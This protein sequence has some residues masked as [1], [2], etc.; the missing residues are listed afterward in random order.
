MKSKGIK[1]GQLTWI[2]GYGNPQRRDDGIGPY[3][4]NQLNTFLKHKKGVRI[5]TLNQLEPDL[6]NKLRHAGIIIF[7]DATMDEVEGG[8]TWAKIEP[9]L[10]ILPH[11]TYYFKPSF[12]LGLLQSIYHICPP[13]WLVSVQGDDFEFGEELTREAEKRAQRVVSEINEFI[14]SK[15]Y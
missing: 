5:L 10:E 13:T 7:V 6:V 2:I 12:F 8:W 3:V 4:A 1:Q 15:N 11:L 14:L 9:E